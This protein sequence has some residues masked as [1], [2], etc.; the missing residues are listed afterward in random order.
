[1]IQKKSLKAVTLSVF[2]ALLATI[3]YLPVATASVQ[4][5]AGPQ[6]VQGALPELSGVSQ[7]YQTTSSLVNVLLYA[8]RWI[9]TIFFI[10]AVLFILLAAYNFIQGGNNPEKVKTAKEQL[11]Y[12]VI[13]IVVALIATGVSVIIGNFLEQA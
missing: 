6:E 8:T 5:G 2:I 9:Y 10:V 3:S 13:A 12:A 7:K 4:P 11:K 1:M